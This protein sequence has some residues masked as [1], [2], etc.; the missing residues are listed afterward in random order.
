[1]RSLLLWKRLR[2]YVRFTRT[3]IANTCAVISTSA[4]II[5]VFV[6]ALA[7]LAILGAT[8]PTVRYVRR[9]R[10]KKAAPALVARQ[11]SQVLQNHSESDSD[12]S[13]GQVPVM[14]VIEVAFPWPNFPESY[15]EHVLVPNSQEYNMIADL[16]YDNNQIL[17]TPRESNTILYPDAHILRIVRIQNRAL[18]MGYFHV[19]HD[20]MLPKYAE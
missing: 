3:C 12:D 11:R 7:V 5:I 20:I 6:V 4:I 14:N 2:A 17:A 13:L 9:R 8:I 19:K 16:F 1:M 18:W 10:E 15:A